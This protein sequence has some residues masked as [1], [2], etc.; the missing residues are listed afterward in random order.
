MFSRVPDPRDPQLRVA[1]GSGGG[2]PQGST[3][4][5]APDS[6]GKYLQTS[7]KPNKC[8]SVSEELLLRVQVRSLLKTH[9]PGLEMWYG[10]GLVAS[11]WLSLDRVNT[12]CTYVIQ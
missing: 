12:C 4:R 6:S 3:G 7:L 11:C 1:R 10:G 9:T 2:C 5:L 8:M